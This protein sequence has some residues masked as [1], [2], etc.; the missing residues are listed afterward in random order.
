[1]KGNDLIENMI[2][3]FFKGSAP[4]ELVAQ[5]PAGMLW[6]AIRRENARDIELHAIFDHLLL[7]DEFFLL[8][9]PIPAI[10]NGL[11][12]EFVRVK[13][14]DLFSKDK[15]AFWELIWKEPAY[16]VS[17]DFKWMIAMTTENTS[18]GDQLCVLVSASRKMDTD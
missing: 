15:N 3:A 12:P 6:E 9:E 4:S 7:H 11:D 10:Q 18:R 14:A 8:P 17:C 2:N 13:S 1:M 5:C 16:L